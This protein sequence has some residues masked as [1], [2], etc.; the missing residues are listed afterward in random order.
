M[1]FAASIDWVEYVSFYLDYHCMGIEIMFLV[2][3]N[4]IFV[5]SG[6]W[7]SFFE[8]STIIMKPL[9]ILALNY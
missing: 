7:Q 5:N 2:N 8:V 6:N 4:F 9:T 1:H 3:W